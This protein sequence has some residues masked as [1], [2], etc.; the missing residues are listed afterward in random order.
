MFS[1]LI[2]ESLSLFEVFSYSAQSHHW[3]WICKWAFLPLPHQ[4]QVP[5]NVM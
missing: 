3:G 4:K 1:K 2:F 5:I